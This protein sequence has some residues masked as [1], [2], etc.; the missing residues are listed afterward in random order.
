MK[1][2]LI[3]LTFTLVSLL[4]F[5]CTRT[6]TKSD[7][8]VSAATEVN[9]EMNTETPEEFFNLPLSAREN[10]QK[11]QTLAEAMLKMPPTF[12]FLVDK[13]HALPEDFIP[14]DIV[15]LDDYPSLRTGRDG[16]KLERQA[17]EALT[18]MSEAAEKDGVRLVISSAY[19][20]YD[21]QKAL[22]QRYAERDGEEAAS[23]YSAK[24]GTSQH[25]LGTTVDLGSI[26]DSFAETPAG[27]WMNQNAGNYGWSLSY[28]AG[29]EDETGYK[30]ESWHWRFIGT[31]AVR[32]Q[33]DYFQGIQ[34]RLL[35]YWN[36]NASR[37]REAFSED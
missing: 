11:F 33:K 17:A 8:Q 13:N 7:I 30:G 21:Y 22:F 25:Q 10:P 19:R 29:Y 15:N 1:Y 20:S 4:Y 12:L 6:S 27:I 26:S 35:V 36:E 16:L 2:I 24:P 28:P 5:S 18:V 9:A 14:A 31:A 32:M 34:Q 3:P 37:I 23:R